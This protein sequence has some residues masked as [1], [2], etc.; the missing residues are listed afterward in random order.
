MIMIMIIK[1]RNMTYAEP[2]YAPLETFRS[3]YYYQTHA[4]IVYSHICLI[5]ITPV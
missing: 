1:C 2:S 5:G 4:S 3:A